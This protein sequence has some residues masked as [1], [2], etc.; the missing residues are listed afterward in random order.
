[1]LVQSP[2]SWEGAA[3]ADEA[4]LA[5]A[6]AELLAHELTHALMYQ[7]LARGDGAPVEEPPLWFREGMA[8][9]TAGQ[10]ARRLS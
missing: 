6:L 10:G 9:L 8:S 3:E 1:V 2:R 5:A 7:R 4:T